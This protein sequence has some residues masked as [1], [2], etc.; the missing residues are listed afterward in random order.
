MARWPTELSRGF[1]L[2]A[3]VVIGGACAEVPGD[4]VGVGVAPVIYGDD[5]RVDPSMDHRDLPDGAAE[6]SVALV[7]SAWELE[8]FHHLDGGVDDSDAGADT[9]TPT[10]GERF[11]LCP[12]ERFAQQPSLSDCSGVLISSDIVLTAGHCFEVSDTCDRYV[13]GF[14]FRR[15]DDAGTIVPRFRDCA[16]LVVREVGQLD[17]GSTVDYAL[18]RLERAA[19]ASDVTPP[20]VRLDGVDPGETMTTV[21]HPLGLPLKLEP[22]GEVVSADRTGFNLLTDVYQGSSGSGV[23][24]SSEHLAGLLTGGESDFEWDADRRCQSSRI[25]ASGDADIGERAM[26]VRIALARACFRIPDLSVCELL[27]PSQ[28]PGMGAGASDELKPSASPRPKRTL[29]GPDAGSFDTAP[30]IRFAAGEPDGLSADG[31][32]AGGSCSVAPGPGRG[33]G[34]L[35]ILM[36]PMAWLRQRRALG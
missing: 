6:R 28:T 18:V 11:E 14:G 10:A 4:A 34:W 17:D 23:Y 30:P 26:S 16:E 2:C 32:A 25:I 36:G 21:G 8:V 15:T 24:D 7:A 12:E 13:Y 29:P 35:W 3:V 5:D 33:S 22:A 31:G 20:S 27:R 9:E 19:T 1:G